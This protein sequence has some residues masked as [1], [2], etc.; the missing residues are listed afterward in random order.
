MS[1]RH[2]LIRLTL[3]VVKSRASAMTMYAAMTILSK[4][5]GSMPIRMLMKEIEKTIE[6]SDWEKSIL[7]N[8]GNIRWQSIM[9]FTSVDY[10]L[11]LYCQ[12]TLLQSWIVI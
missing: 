1:K 12:M 8:T 5:G 11:G 2:T 9:H 7:E 6:L 4:N 3:W 10:V